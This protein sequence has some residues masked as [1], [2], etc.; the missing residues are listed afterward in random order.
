[1][2]M[3]INNMYDKAFADSVHCDTAGS[4]YKVGYDDGLGMSGPCP[5]GH[6]SGFCRGWDD[7]TGGS[8]NNGSSPALE[9]S[10]S[11]QQTTQQNVSTTNQQTTSNLANISVNI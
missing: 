11:N 7:A 1:M 4:C 9:Q 6:S 8:N 2:M 5:S 3:G 10:A